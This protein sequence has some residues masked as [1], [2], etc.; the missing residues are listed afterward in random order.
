MTAAELLLLASMLAPGAELAGDAPDIARAIATVVA[1]ERDHLYDEETDAAVMLVYAWRESRFQSHA[2]GDGGKAKGAWQLHMT[3][4]SVAFRPL[5][6][7][8]RWYGWAREG[9][10]YWPACPL[11]G[12]SG[13]GERGARIAGERLTFARALLKRLREHHVPGLEAGF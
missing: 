1:E 10:R 3:V 11:Q 7:A 4:P 6:A 8:R 5:L 9:R 13:G 12:I 2:V